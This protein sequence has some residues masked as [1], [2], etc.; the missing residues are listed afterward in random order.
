MVCKAGRY[1]RSTKLWL[2]FHVT[3]LTG[4]PYYLRQLICLAVFLFTTDLSRW[5][6]ASF[7]SKVQLLL[8]K[9]PEFDPFKSWFLEHSPWFIRRLELESCNK[10][11]VAGPSLSPET[12]WVPLLYCFYLTV[13]K[14]TRFD[15]FGRFQLAMVRAKPHC[16][17]RGGTR[18]LPTN[19]QPHQSSS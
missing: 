6:F 9:K 8:S 11:S 18:R 19:N 7:Y 15:L 14:E 17:T 5:Q 1:S 3:F 2:F 16:T 13:M 12:C 10:R 4:S